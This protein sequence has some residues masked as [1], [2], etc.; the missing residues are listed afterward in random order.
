MEEMEI[1]KNKKPLQRVATISLGWAFVLVGIVG[2]LLP[3]VPGGLLI[4]L[5]AL[6]LDSQHPWLRRVLE[7]CRARFPIL[8]RA[9]RR[10]SSC[11][12]TWRSRFTNYVPGKARQKLGVRM[13]EC[14]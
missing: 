12:R 11:G 9:T 6:M 1:V 2:L 5:G 14:E 10:I 3:V 7:K 13:S 8:E 4:V